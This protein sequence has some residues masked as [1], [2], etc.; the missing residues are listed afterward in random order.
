MKWRNG[1]FTIVSI[2][3][4]FMISGCEEE[5]QLNCPEF[6]TEKGWEYQNNV[7]SENI[8]FGKDGAFSYYES[9][10]N[11][12]GDSDLYEEYSYDEETGIITVY[13]SEAGMDEIQIGVLRYD[14]KSLLLNFDE[15]IKEFCIDYSIPYLEAEANDYMKDYSSYAAIIHREEDTI[16]TAPSYY[17]GDIA[18]HREKLQRQENLAK[19]VEYYELYI[20]TMETEEE[21]TQ[22]HEYTKLSDKE[23]DQLLEGTLGLGFVWYNDD[24]EIEKIVFYG[25]ITIQE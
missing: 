13:P 23:V 17:D 1:L 7:C 3:F 12:V 8:W 2:V 5:R 22:N 15:G 14:E 18:K 20:E 16:V 24:V 10:G 9:C 11:P 19:D 21:V 4:V 25:E 6:L